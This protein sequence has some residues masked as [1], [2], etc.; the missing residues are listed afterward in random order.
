MSLQIAHNAVVAKLIGAD[1]TTAAMVSNLLSY[2]VEGAEFAHSFKSGHWNGRSTF[3]SHRSM[4]FPAGFVHLVHHELRNA[5]LDPQI[6]RTAAPLPLGPENPVVDSF[7]DD[8]RYDYQMKAVRQVE[9]HGRGVIQLA[10]GGGKSRVAKFLMMRY[11]RPTLFLTTRG[12]LMYQMQDALRESG[13]KSGIIGDSVWSPSKFITLGMVQT[14]VARLEEP[15]E[16]AEIR[17]LVKSYAAKGISVNRAK[18]VRE[19]QTKFAEKQALRAKT[20]KLLEM[21][22]VV[23]G[24]EAHEAGGNSYYKIL[25]HCKNAH[26]RVALTA[27]PFMRDAQEDNMRL[28]AAFGPVL[29][30]VSEKTLI[31]RGILAKPYFKYVDVPPNAKLKKT[32]PYQRARQIGIVECINRNTIIVTEAAKA[33]KHGL[34][35]MI[36]VQMKK[37]G[38]ILEQM[39]AKTGIEAHFI[40]G[41]SDQAERKRALN[42]L[43]SGDIKVLIG[44]TILD[45]GVDVPAVGMVILAGGGK[46]EVNL[47]QRVGRGLRSKKKN[48]LCFVLDFT[49]KTNKHLKD[50]ARQRHAIIAG[51]PGFAEQILLPGE[52]FPWHLIE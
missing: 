28:M 46:A 41:E 31:E 14:L 36:L 6:V 5:G 35:V 30:K 3:F 34:P 2:Y 50:H 27:T 38:V 8:P 21:I 19:A 23:I 43:K 16:G 11:K 44:T 1:T 26:I 51:T 12:V 25:R 10:T 39:L 24:E 17:D 13:I 42:G 18:L 29:I 37:H 33:V 40:Q 9:R 20:L 49:D 45:V 48:N 4:S 22:E 47:R 15:D 32:S 7:G 52:D